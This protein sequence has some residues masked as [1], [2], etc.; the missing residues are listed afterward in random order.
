MKNSED[1]A[2]EYVVINTTNGD[3]VE[4]NQPTTTGF[5]RSADDIGAALDG[6]VFSFTAEVDGVMNISY[7]VGGNSVFITSINV[8]AG[9]HYSFDLTATIQTIKNRLNTTQ[10]PVVDFKFQIIDGTKKYQPLTMD[11]NEFR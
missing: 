4:D 3:S 9:G 6:E 10:V 11:I 1:N 8:T 7:V 5:S 2:Y